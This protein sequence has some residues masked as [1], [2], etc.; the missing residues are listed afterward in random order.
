MEGE[1]QSPRAAGPPTSTVD[2]GT[3]SSSQPSRLGCKFSIR[4]T[5]SLQGQGAQ[6]ERPGAD[7]IKPFAIVIC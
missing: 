6:L 7:L 4:S 1:Y 5:P 3:P 2:P